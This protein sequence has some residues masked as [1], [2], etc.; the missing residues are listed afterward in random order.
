MSFVIQG[1]YTVLSPVSII[2]MARFLGAEEFGIFAFAISI[3]TLL[4]MVSELGLPTVITR[5]GAIYFFK[6]QFEFFK[7][8]VRFTNSRIIIASLVLVL[9]VVITYFAGIIKPEYESAVLLAS[10][11]VL[12]LALSRV[13]SAILTA[14]E[15]VNIA[16][17]PEMIFRPSL[18]IISILLLYYFDK[19]SAINVLILYIIVNVIVYLIGEWLVKRHSKT[20]KLV[21]QVDFERKKWI[22]SAFPLFLLGGIQMIGVQSDIFLLGFFADSED[23]GIFKSMYQISLLII[24]SLTAVNAISAPKIVRLYESNNVEGL[25]KLVINFC[26]INLI[27]SLII[28]FPFY[29]YG[30]Y[31]I[32][33]LYGEEYVVGFVCLQILIIGRIINT[34]F[35]I[36]SQFLKMMGEEKKAANGVL[37][38]ALISVVLNIILIP[39][40]GLIGAAYASAISLAFWNLFLFLILVRKLWFNF[41]KP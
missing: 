2:L 19:I 40:F 28:A 27:F 4:S 14:I 3:V 25:K 17:F 32:N 35:G 31:F 29:F 24:F 12:L 8:I 20:I 6:N 36:S 23:V 33:L 41:D 39:R 38:G 7:G 9:G 10:P 30:D 21:K 13:R 22:A 11:L 37:L 16:Q 1:V 5:F 15:K 26:L 34:V 18:L